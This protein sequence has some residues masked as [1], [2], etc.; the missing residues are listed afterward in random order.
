MAASLPAHTLHHTCHH[1]LASASSAGFSGSL[2]RGVLTREFAAVE[3]GDSV[4]GEGASYSFSTDPAGGGGGRAGSAFAPP[5]KKFEILSR[6]GTSFLGAAGGSLSK[7][8]ATLLVLRRRDS[9]DARARTH[10]S[11]A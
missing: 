1:G 9:D 2:G 6:S 4:I 7:T 11:S 8:E 5:T 3:F 10:A